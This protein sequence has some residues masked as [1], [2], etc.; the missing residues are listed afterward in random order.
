M[1]GVRPNASENGQISPSTTVRAVRGD[2]SCPKLASILPE[3]RKTA[4]ICPNSGVIRGI[5]VNHSP[6]EHDNACWRASRCIP[7]GK[8]LLELQRKPTTDRQDADCRDEH[9]ARYK[10]PAASAGIADR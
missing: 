9:D 6:A 2:G 1:G 5:P 3:G 4:N 10:H 8:S 7:T